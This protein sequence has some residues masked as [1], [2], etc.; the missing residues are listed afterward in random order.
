MRPVL[1]GLLHG[2]LRFTLLAT[3]AS[4]GLGTVVRAAEPLKLVAPKATF[5]TGSS[6]NFACVVDGVETGPSG[7]SVAGRATVPH[8]LVATC[9]RPVKA[10]ELDV[11]L[12]FLAGRPLNYLADF[13]LSFTTDAT[14]SL[15]GN[16][17][18][19]EILR[20]NSQA[21]TLQRTSSSGLRAERIPYSVNG[22]LPDEI[23]RLTTVLPGG[24]ATGFRLDARPVP[25]TPSGDLLGMSWHVPHDFTLTEFR[26]AVHE[27]ET[28]NIALYRPVRTSHPLY[29]NYDGTRMRAEALTDG[30]PATIAHPELLPLGSGFFFEIDLGQ[31]VNLDHIGLRNRGDDEFERFSRVAVN[32]YE[33]PS[34]DG[35]SP[36]WQGMARTDGSHPPPGAVEILHQA[37]GRGVFRGRHLRISSDNPLPYTPQL[38][39]VEVYP[40][41]T[42]ELVSARAD[43]H[44]L[45]LADGLVIPPGV[46]HLTLDLRILQPGRPAGDL[47]RWRIRGERENWESSPLWSLDLACPPPGRTVFEAQALHSDG[48]WDASIYRL[49][50]LVRQHW[51]KSGLFQWTSGFLMTVLAIGSGVFVAR[52]RA[53]RQIARMKA[54]TALA[55]ERARI[56]RDMHDEVGGKLARLAM[57]GDL[58]LTGRSGDEATKTR[59]ASL[60]RG[61]REVAAELEQVIWSLNPKQDRI[62]NLVR[63]IYQYAEEFFSN[64]PV[65]CRFGSMDGIPD[66]LKL[67]PEPRTALFRAFQE[68]I[69]NVLK[70]AHASMVD[71]DVIWQNNILE[72]SVSDNGRGFDPEQAAATS[73]RNGLSNMLD[74]MAGIGGSCLIESSASGTNVRLR[75]AYHDGA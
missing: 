53:A 59:V 21:A 73:E 27:R 22:A 10:E 36:I 52:R 16:W 64:T 14:P 55:A 4:G 12:F 6:E 68:A 51:W 43:G 38:A 39:E 45:P 72:I 35:R 57:L 3:L 42:P 62:D 67:H 30:L 74:R 24:Y 8:S 71:I 69:A 47:F 9:A 46:R 28:T 44:E 56:A 33:M 25:L 11:S 1:I 75:W 48:Q 54:E 19:L 32:L 41:R 23:Y 29:L 2:F 37:D 58:A 15:S 63:H 20:F 18:P 40:S 66:K 61:V 5:F 13:S 49:P 70:H 26:V 60:T 17:Q 34:G 50:I 7:W 31:V 65:A